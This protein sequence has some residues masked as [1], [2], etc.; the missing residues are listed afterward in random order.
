[1][2]WEALTHPTQAHV[3]TCLTAHQDGEV[4]KGLFSLSLSLVC[5]C[6]LWQLKKS[7]I[8]TNGSIANQK[9]SSLEIWAQTN[10]IGVSFNI[11][12]VLPFGLEKTGIGLKGAS[13]GF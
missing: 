8:Y 7:S 11:V 9:S 10:K 4:E 13:P 12:Q 2:G 1:M 5:K 6:A 3:R